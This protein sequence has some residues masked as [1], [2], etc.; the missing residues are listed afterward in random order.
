MIKFCCRCNQKF[1]V[2]REPAEWRIGELRRFSKVSL[3]IRRRLL[4]CSGDYLCG[5]CYLGLTLTD[6]CYPKGHSVSE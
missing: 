5:A 3:R 6:N 1:P 2:A 4:H